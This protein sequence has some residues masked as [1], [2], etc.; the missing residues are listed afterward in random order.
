MSIFDSILLSVTNCWKAA[1]IVK[2]AIMLRPQ[3]DDWIVAFCASNRNKLII[4]PQHLIDILAIIIAIE[5][6]S[7]AFVC[8]D[9]Q[10][11]RTIVTAIAT[12]CDRRTM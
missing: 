12:F 8:D 7:S 4:K 9:F 2:S 1:R 11:K 3:Q 10:C 6:E 5:S